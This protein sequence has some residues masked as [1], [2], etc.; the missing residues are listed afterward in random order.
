MSDR[1][2]KARRPRAGARVGLLAVAALA[3]ASCA[4]LRG[5]GDELAP[6][7]A[8]AAPG[9][10]D[11][12]AALPTR[13]TP[14]PDAPDFAAHDL[15]AAT[16]AGTPEAALGAQRRLEELERERARAGAPPSGLAA[17]GR[18]L[19]DA[20]EPDPIA[21]RRASAALLRRDDVDPALRRRLELE[22]ADDPLELADAR[23]DDARRARVARGVNALS[24]AAGRSLTS[25]VFAPI[26]IAQALV[27]VAVAEHMDDPISVQER[28]AL[29]HWKQY[30][31]TNPGSPETPALLGRIEKMQRRWL[32][33][34]RER[35][36]RTARLAL[37]RGQD[38][39]ALVLA[40][41]ALLYAPEDPEA[42]ALR[43]EAERRVEAWRRARANSLEA[44]PALPPGA[45]GPPAAALARALLD[46]EGDVPGAAAALL[47]SGGSEG[48]LADEAR[49]A[50]ALAAGERGE[51][52]RGW[53]LLGRV[54][55]ER[56][57]D[58]EMARHAAW[59]IAS[60]ETNPF[61]AF[62]AARVDH[63]GERANFVL[64]G[65]L[66]R[67]ARDRDLPRPVEY[68]LE[69]PSLLGTIGGIPSRLL[70]ALVVTKPA[71]APAIHARRYLARHPD[72]ARSDEVREWLIGYS[73]D[74]GNALAA[75]ELAR[76][77]GEADPERLAELEREAA[78]QMLETAQKQKRQDLR[79]TMLGMIAK[80]H[81]DTEAGRRAGELAHQELTQATVQSI[82]ITRGF[83]LENPEIAG[84]N[85]VGLRP[86]LLDGRAYGGEL[87]PDGVRLVGGRV[88]EFSLVAPG[89]DEDDPP[90]L[91]R[92]EVSRER[93]ARLVAL[94]EETTIHNA[95]LDP[96]DETAPDARRDH[97]FERA[98]L[99]VADAPDTRPSATS[100]YTFVGVREKYGMVRSRESI[101]PVELVVQGSFP[102]L[103]L[104]AFP[105]LRMPKKTPD[106]VLYQ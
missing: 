90:E 64:L 50:E 21:R 43:N 36:V 4:S 54:S 10:P 67:G 25:T 49:F 95:L 89:G 34:K 37:E 70:Q 33:S 8:L 86:E 45:T 93:L 62:Q 57:P 91:L 26:R 103:G 92:R 76:D 7:P 88:L 55:G 39:A 5:G 97:F 96:L 9:T 58:R 14:L 41:R 75:W 102:D 78:R 47:A 48:P 65:P 105:R 56:G 28:Q 38:E 59:L 73:Q 87:H 24:E 32:E 79:L 17:R 23:I 16:L 51:E 15:A 66:A 69:G 22:V 42:A 44:A 29:A 46:P 13:G 1:Q 77:G 31:E 40:S 61:A 63:A 18:Y 11:P 94:L 68:L 104:G 20:T 106:A 53:E 98:K 35:G 80:D 84:P 101:L 74:S 52:S 83:L 3:A 99:G 60:P 19:L 27:G 12:L 2:R 71:R 82:R 85:G 30:V 72:G 6:P 100:T 81:P